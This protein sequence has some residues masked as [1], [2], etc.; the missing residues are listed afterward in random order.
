MAAL[1]PA[2]GERPGRGSFLNLFHGGIGAPA[3]GTASFREHGRWEMGDVAN[4]RKKEGRVCR[5]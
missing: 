5:L 2:D 4:A 3:S 1:M